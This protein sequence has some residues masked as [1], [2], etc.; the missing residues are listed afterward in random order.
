MT[1]GHCLQALMIPL[2][3]AMALRIHSEAQD[4]S[5][6]HIIVGHLT[7]ANHSAG[8]WRSRVV[9]LIPDSES[10]ESNEGKQNN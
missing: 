10:L 9:D 2:K 5:F 3:G 7:D 4:C 1:F 8:S 6:R